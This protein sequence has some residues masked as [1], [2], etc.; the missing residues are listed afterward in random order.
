MSTDLLSFEHPSVLLFCLDTLST[1]DFGSNVKLNIIDLKLSLLYLPALRFEHLSFE[2]MRWNES[3]LTHGLFSNI[4]GR[5]LDILDLGHNNIGQLTS[6]SL[7]G[8]GHLSTLDLSWNRLTSCDKA[9]IELS[10]LVKLDLTSNVLTEYSGEHLPLSLEVLMMRNNSFMKFPNLC[11]NNGS[12]T[13]RKLKELRIQENQINSLHRNFFSCM[14][15]LQVLKLR[16]NSIVHFPSD[17]FSMMKMLISLDLGDMRS[18]VQTIEK[19][20][21]SIPSLRVFKFDHNNFKFN[22]YRY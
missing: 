16:K 11:E 21:F 10:S 9:Q 19:N 18:T 14:P 17:V 1:I 12:F 22:R 15:S 7:R 5:V 3:H 2:Y 20:A 8:L 4:K 6:D 13:G